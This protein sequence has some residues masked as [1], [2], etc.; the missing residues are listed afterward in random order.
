VTANL[1]VE[2]HG[3]AQ[4]KRRIYVPQPPVVRPLLTTRQ[5]QV[6]ELLRQGV[7]SHKAIAFAMGWTKNGTTVHLCNCYRRLQGRGYRVSSLTDLAVFAF[8]PEVMKLDAAAR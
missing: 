8:A 2:Y 6:V 3:L 1:A 7:S 4:P 5:A